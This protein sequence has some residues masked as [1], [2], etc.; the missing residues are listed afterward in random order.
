MPEVILTNHGYNPSDVWCTFNQPYL[1]EYKDFSH[2][3]DKVIQPNTAGQPRPSSL[4]LGILLRTVTRYKN[5]IFRFSSAFSGNASWSEIKRKAVWAKNQITWT[6]VWTRAEANEGCIVYCQKS[7]KPRPPKMFEKNCLSSSIAGK[8]IDLRRERRFNVE[9]KCVFF[10]P[11]T[12]SHGRPCVHR[13]S[14]AKAE[15]SWHLGGTMD[16]NSEHGV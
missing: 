3:M 15:S 10:S 4:I 12:F 5:R 8:N 2:Y 9:S 1:D 6:L 13:G 7:L 16:E 14:S 11:N